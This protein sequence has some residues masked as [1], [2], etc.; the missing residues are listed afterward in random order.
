[1]NRPSS[2]I[3]FI[4]LLIAAVIIFIYS[5][6]YNVAATIPHTKLALWLLNETRE[7]SIKSRSKDIVVPPMI[8]KWEHY[9]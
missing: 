4:I 8:K 1:M 7:H 9:L 6:V 2:I 3:A 5:G